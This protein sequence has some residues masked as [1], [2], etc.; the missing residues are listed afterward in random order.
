[1][2]LLNCFHTL[3]PFPSKHNFPTSSQAQIFFACCIHFQINE[4]TQGLIFKRPMRFLARTNTESHQKHLYFHKVIHQSCISYFYHCYG[5]MPS[6]N[7]FSCPKFTFDSWFQQVMCTVTQPVLS[8][9]PS[10]WKE[11]RVTDTIYLKT[12]RNCHAVKGNWGL[13]RTI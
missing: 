8:Q 6:R 11:C 3:S 12:D 1:M 9:K 2:H 13:D 5:R 10:M 7:S 4:M